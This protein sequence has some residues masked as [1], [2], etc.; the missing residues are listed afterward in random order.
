MDGLVIKAGGWLALALLALVMAALAVDAPFAV[1]MGI[2]AVAALAGQ[3]GA[4]LFELSKDAFAKV[5]YRERPDGLLAVAPQWKRTL[6][7]LDEL[8]GRA[9]RPTVGDKPRPT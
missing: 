5:A 2:V 6:A 9:L 4:Q 1:H 3:A 8:V 7:D